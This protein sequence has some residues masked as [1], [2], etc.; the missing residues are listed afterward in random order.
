[1]CVCVHIHKKHMVFFFFVCLNSFTP[2]VTATWLPLKNQFLQLSSHYLALIP[3]PDFWMFACNLGMGNEKS[4]S[5]QPQDW[6][7]HRKATR[8]NELNNLQDFTSTIKKKTS[9]LLSCSA[10][11]LELP[12]ASVATLAT[13]GNNLPDNQPTQRKA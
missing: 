11:S 6:F 5:L 9:F 12:G 8:L 1:M 2:H 10:V 13:F 3:L 7:R 4:T